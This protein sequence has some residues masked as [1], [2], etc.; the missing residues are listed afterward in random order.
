MLEREIS[1]PDAARRGLPGFSRSSVEPAR[2]VEILIKA[3]ST[4]T[5]EAVVSAIEA[6]KTP[7]IRVIRAEVGNIGKSDLLIAEAGSRLIIG[8][9]VEILPR[10]KEAAKEHQVEVRLYS[11]IYDLLDGL[12]KIASSLNETAVESEKILGKGKVIALFTSGRK[13]IIVGC[14]VEEGVLTV[15]KRFR[16]ISDPGPVY[17]G[18]IESLHIEK[19][20]VKQ[21][22]AGQQV[23]I[24]IS[25]F[26]R[27]KIG[28]LVESFHVER[29][30]KSSRWQPKGGIFRF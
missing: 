25:G 21:A 29:T 3:D 2:R 19:D 6:L 15:G 27:V 17:V 14:Q 7:G 12:K 4:G 18:N 22:K 1:S 11:V 8:F 13:D 16:I 24:K 10:V 26:K 5:L 20:S 9:N 23:G 30:G 28:D